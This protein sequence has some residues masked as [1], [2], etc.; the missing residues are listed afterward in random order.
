MPTFD[1]QCQKC[2]TTFEFNRPFG[3]K[4]NPPCPGCASKKTEKLMSVPAIAFKGS[5]WYKTDSRATTIKRA[6]KKEPIQGTEGT[7]GTD[8]T[9]AA[10]GTKT[11]EAPGPAADSKPAKAV[12]E[13]KSETKS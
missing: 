2:K 3:S 13:K 10:E 7:K 6:E 11:A 4:A 9:K 1:F 12:P 5:G 8:G